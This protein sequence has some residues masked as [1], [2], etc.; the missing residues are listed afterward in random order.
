MNDKVSCLTQ[1][2]PQVVVLQAL[3]EVNLQGRVFW[4]GMDGRNTTQ[5]GFQIRD[6]IHHGAELIPFHYRFN[7]PR[8][9]R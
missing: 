5:S 7:F 9:L 1:N 3:L 8:V 6:I 4:I 2:V